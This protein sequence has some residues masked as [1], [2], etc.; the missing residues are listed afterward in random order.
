MNP[1]GNVF[2]SQ[3]NTRLLSAEMQLP[4]EPKPAAEEAPAGVKGISL[5]TLPTAKEG[6]LEPEE[7]PDW[8][9]ELTEQSLG[10]PTE[11]PG[12]AEP[13]PADQFPDWLS[14]LADDTADTVTGETSDVSSTD[15][16][17]PEEEPALSEL[18]D[19]F[20][21]L[22]G[23]TS[24]PEMAKPEEPSADVTP[25]WFADLLEEDETTGGEVEA[26]SNL[27][28][29]AFEEVEEEEPAL[30]EL[31]DWL[32]DLTPE[33][34]AA[35]LAEDIFEMA[36]PPSAWEA[37]TPAGPA[38]SSPDFAAEPRAELPDWLLATAVPTPSGEAPV[39]Q[40]LPEWLSKNAEEFAPA[41][42][43]GG[44]SG[45]GQFPTWL[46]KGAEPSTVSAAPRTPAPSHPEPVEAAPTPS[47][48]LEPE[49]APQASE[50]EAGTPDWLLGIYEE[51]SEPQPVTPAEEPEVEET[52]GDLPDWLAD[53]Y[54]EEEGEPQATVSTTEPEEAVA[55]TGEAAGGLP[56]WL[57]GIYNEEEEEPAGAVFTAESEEEE[58]A[59][60][61]AVPD[62]LA[63]VMAE[64]PVSAQPQIPSENEE[65][66]PGIGEA[67]DAMPDWL[68]GLVT[69]TPEEEEKPSPFAEESP[70]FTEPVPEE[71][72]PATAATPDWL[73]GVTAEDEELALEQEQPAFIPSE[74]DSGASEEEYEEPVL[75][76]GEIPDWLKGLQPSAPSPVEEEAAFMERVSEDESLVR[77]EVP[78]WLQ[79][80][81]PPGTGPLPPL[82]EMM[83]PGAE[84]PPPEEGGLVRAEIPDWVQQLRPVPT[85]EGELR[86]LE[87]A[88]TEGPLAG[89]RG[90][91]PSGLAM[92]MPADFQPAPPPAIPE[93]IVAQAQLWQKLLEQPRSVQR[94]VAQYRA[95]S[96]K[97]QLATRLIVAVILLAVTVLGLLWGGTIP[98]SQAISQPHIEHFSK[99]IDAL[100]PGDTVIVAVEYGPA[101][102][103]E[104]TILAEAV[105]QHL[106]D[107]NAQMIVV[108]TLP[109][110]TGLIQGLLK[111][112]ALA[113]HLPVG[114]TAYL[115]GSSNG[116]A[117]FLSAPAEAKMIVVLAGRA[118]R[119][120]WWV[121]QN[122]ATQ[123]L[124]MAMAVNAATA[125]L[126][127][128]YLET[129]SAAG[130]M[131]GLPD[132]AAYQQFR[133][134]T[135]GVLDSQLD[136]L[137]LT[138]WAALA[139]LLFGLFYYLAL[140]KKGA[141]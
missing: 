139:L 107:R 88:E 137:M 18:P 27:T 3:C 34:P 91:L 45:T 63:G 104:M 61:T 14:G 19:W 92:D 39:S 124:P 93:S 37:D 23:Q 73:K 135:S 111:P 133:G 16:S 117:Q 71:A 103:G 4:E 70:I 84:V 81:R 50:P 119:L 33:E 121:E 9:L 79:G 51:E 136:A 141:S 129:P 87:P 75:E 6:A 76:G 69:E 2:C 110:G 125:P 22:A 56:D 100:E 21:E 113:N 54:S 17:T 43:T 130:W 12:A 123:V 95:R 80:L 52:A 66:A 78:T 116:V 30:E 20:S 64:E 94:P 49:E 32:S 7:L 65:T 89:L 59:P 99:A 120:R 101:E 47:A 35:A 126:A 85:A 108:S 5:P 29:S 28:A 31:P 48:V 10:K 105:M 40:P 68:S 114:Q 115:P 11:T 26:A 1:I 82:P 97:G 118:E 83:V 106:A 41:Q 13:T 102:A 57:A 55:E 8:L 77:A 112:L 53:I 128:P 134:L 127:M 109:E 138:H 46:M 58:I 131:A 38:P 36:P 60:E 74:A 67:A 62:W 86:S 96:G 122:N 90:V 44:S 98:L 140:G 25:D 15:E 132:V 42:E 24:T 72:S